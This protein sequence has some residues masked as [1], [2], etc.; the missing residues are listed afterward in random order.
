MAK[1][2]GLV[3]SDLHAGSAF[4]LLPPDFISAEN[5]HIMPNS[6]QEYLYKHFDGLLKRL[7][8]RQIDF[9]VVNGD[10]MDGEQRKTN[11]DTLALHRLCDQREAAY[12]LLR[13]WQQAFPKADWHFV[14]GT[15]YHEVMPEVEQLTVML[16]GEKKTVNR[17]LKLSIGDAVLSFNHEIS[18]TGDMKG[19]AMEKEIIREL[20]AMAEHGWEAS[21]AL[22]RSHLHTYRLLARQ[23][24]LC[25][26]SPCWQL[27]TD[28]MSRK[29]TTAMIPS[30]GAIVLDVDDGLKQY[31]MCPVSVTPYLY[32][33]P[34]PK[35]VAIEE[36]VV[37][38]KK[39]N[40]KAA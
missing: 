36:P 12:K 10:I 6:G 11:G 37:I 3:L 8:P 4:G 9:I 28:F 5:N 17:S 19:N 16:F 26:I 38:G 27:Q 14:T 33:H 30:L 20:T 2:T 25:V 31:G 35:I 22:I 21:D 29:S 39:R 18:G 34:A 40:A 32:K 24:K 1:A 7:A 13:P 15:R 23:D